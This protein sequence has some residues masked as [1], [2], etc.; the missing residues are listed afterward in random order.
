MSTRSIIVVTNE[1]ETIRLYKHSDGYPTDNLILIKESLAK[2]IDQCKKHF[3]S[4]KVNPQRTPRVDQVSGLLVGFSTTCYG[5]GARI[6]EKHRGPFVPKHLG[7]QGDLEWIYIVDLQHQ[8][9]GVYGGGYTGK[10]PQIAFKK[11]PVDPKIYATSLYLEY[12]KET[13]E[14]IT[15]EMSAI[16]KL[17]FK[18]ASKTKKRA[19]RVKTKEMVGAAV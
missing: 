17:G 5:I 18:F 16:D 14:A 1:I 12:Q 6:E 8:T 3:V 15:E 4:Y 10:P 9:I 2:A 7:D 19:K 13:L 11:G